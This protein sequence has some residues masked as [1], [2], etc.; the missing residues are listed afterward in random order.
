MYSG[1]TLQYNLLKL[2]KKVPKSTEFTSRCRHRTAYVVIITQAGAVCHHVTLSSVITSPCH[3][4]SRHPVVCHHVALLSVITSPC[5]LSSRHPVICHHVTLLSVITSPCHL[6]SRHPVICH[7]VTLSSMC[8][9]IIFH[10]RGAIF[11]PTR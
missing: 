3:L 4:S 6:S 10:W 7:H 9:F 11:V 8:V 2:K 5:Y 1:C